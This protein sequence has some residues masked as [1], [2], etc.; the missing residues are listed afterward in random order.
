[1]ANPNVVAVTSI[2][3]KTVLDADVAASAVTLLTCAS[4]K[5]CKINSLIIANIDGTN[6]ADISV[7]ITRSSADHYIAKGITVA[8]G[9]TLLP[10]DKNM[11]LYLNES[12]ILKIQASAAGDLSAVLSYEEIDDA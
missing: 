6:A 3:A 12:D 11:G 4:E 2:L 7:W 8:A 5:L 1:M 9:S 10:I